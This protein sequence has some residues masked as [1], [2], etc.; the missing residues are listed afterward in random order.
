MTSLLPQ[1][2]AARYR[3]QFVDGLWMRGLVAVLS[4]Y[5]I[6]VLIYFG[7]LYVLKMKYYR[8]K[9]D[10]GSISG[11]YTNA[12]KDAE[13]IKILVARQEL[14]YKALDCWKAVAESLPDSITLEHFYFQ[15]AKIELRGTV[16][17]EDQ[18]TVN[19][20][21]ED[22]RHMANPNEPNQPL[23]SQVAPPFQ[24]TRGNVTD[25]R[26]TCDLKEA[27]NE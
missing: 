27:V 10:L 17:T 25:W 20:F 23:F 15:R 6:G 19:K 26:F 4:A 21:N 3:Q 16:V 7:A 9:Q 8:V 24:Q 13:Q 12:I 2:F 11:S 18:D 22:L 1:D 5:I 14:K